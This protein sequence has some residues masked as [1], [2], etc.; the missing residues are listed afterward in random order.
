MSTYNPVTEDVLVALRDALGAENVKIDEETL[1]R[2]KT[3]EETD[4]R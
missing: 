3:D 4:P 1:D 2:Y